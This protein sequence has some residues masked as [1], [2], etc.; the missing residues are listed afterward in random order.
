MKRRRV[1]QLISCAPIAGLSCNGDPSDSCVEPGQ[2]VV[3]RKGASQMTLDEIER[4]KQAWGLLVLNGELEQ[5]AMGHADLDGQRHHGT[6]IRA[7]YTAIVNP[8]NYAWRFLCWHRAYVLDLEQAMRAAL[9]ADYAARGLDCREA[10]S[11]FVPY[12]DGAQYPDWLREWMPTGTPT[13]VSVPHID[14]TID[15]DSGH[16]SNG[17]AIG[18]TYQAVMRAYE[19]QSWTCPTA[20]PSPRMIAAAIAHDGFDAMSRALESIPGLITEG[21]DPAGAAMVREG[22]EEVVDKE[23]ANAMVYGSFLS[24]A[25]IVEAGGWVTT[26]P[27]EVFGILPALTAIDR[28]RAYDEYGIQAWTEERFLAVVAVINAHI[29]RSPHAVL[30][31]FS[32][33]ESREPGV[34][35]LYGS[36]AYFQDAGADPHFYMLHCEL[37]R[38]FATWLQTHSDQP[39][40]EGEDRLFKTWGGATEWTLDELMDPASVPFAYD[41]LWSAS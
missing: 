39:P 36:S 34:R 15:P 5:L 20:P 37:D 25:D 12:F 1:L 23:G 33:G 27:M 40:L 24:I 14:E 22:A 31:F 3:V 29:Q 9:V 7:D 30:H 8:D 17:L 16:E 11:V 4:F 26:D 41:E 35:G 38:Y 21:P 32:A 6:Q 28:G 13:G 19:G 2:A 10:D 18:E